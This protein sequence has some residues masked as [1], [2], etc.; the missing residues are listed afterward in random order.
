[1]IKSCLVE[2][3]NAAQLIDTAKIQYRE[4]RQGARGSDFDADHHGI[5]FDLNPLIEEIKIYIDNYYY[6][7]DKKLE[8]YWCKVI[9]GHQRRLPAHIINEYCRPDRSFH[10]SN[11]EPPDFL[12]ATL[13]RVGYKEGQKEYGLQ[14][15]FTE[16]DFDN[17]RK[18][19]NSSALVRSIG[20]YAREHRGRMAMPN[21]DGIKLTV[22]YDNDRKSLS[23]LKEVRAQ[24]IEAL[25]EDLENCIRPGMSP[26]HYIYLTKLPINHPYSLVS[27]Q[28]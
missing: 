21:G 16:V 22:P 25:Q 4:V 5:A 20:S 15:F 19:G 9:G 26:A 24:Q 13:P 18:M 1:M 23:K 17:R 3:P 10:G 27:R 8:A 7:S 2:A 11:D 28:G 6:W 14:W 12:D